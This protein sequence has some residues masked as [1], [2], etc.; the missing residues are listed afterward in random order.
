MVESLP[1]FHHGHLTTVALSGAKLPLR[2]YGSK[3]AN[4]AA[5]GTRRPVPDI[6]KLKPRWTPTPLL[7]SG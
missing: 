2:A 5:I 4:S 7:D 3:E 6:T 1:F